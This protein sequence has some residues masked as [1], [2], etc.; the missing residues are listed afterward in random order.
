MVSAQLNLKV[1]TGTVFPNLPMEQSP[2]ETARLP[3][4]NALLEKKEDQ[5]SELSL[6]SLENL[7]ETLAAAAREL[8]EISGSW[9]P[10]ELYTADPESVSAAKEQFLQSYDQGVSSIPQFSYSVAEALDTDSSRHRLHDLLGRVKEERYSRDDRLGRLGR[11]LLIAKIKDD[12]A[13]CDLTQGI[14]DKNEKQIKAALARKYQG[15]DP[16]L[17]AVAHVRY[18][19]LT[20]PEEEASER[21]ALFSPQEQAF[22]HGL[23]LDAGQIK[24]AFEWGLEK[25]GILRTGEEGEGFRVIVDERATAIDVRDKSS[26]GPVVIIP[27][28]RVVDGERILGLLNHEIGSHARQSMNGAKLFKI[29]G[30]SLKIDDETLYEGLAMR[31][32]NAFATAY[33]GKK[34]SYAAPFYTL[35]IEKAE[36]GGTFPDVFQTVLDAKL[37]VALKI[38]PANPLPEDS[39]PAIRKSAKNQAWGITYRVMR[40]HVDMAN[41]EQFAMTKDLAYL[42]GSLLDRQLV[43]EGWGHLNEAAVVAGGGGLRALAEFSLDP[44]DLPIPRADLAKDYFESVLKPRMIMGSLEGMEGGS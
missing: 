2:S 13:T 4:I 38:D 24:D 22:L 25:M 28:T 42:R 36:A 29:G 10:V 41:P 33:F 35:A 39:D 27:A 11:V 15:T 43:A 18:A 12:L 17:I 16:E 1:Y 6:S 21:H 23:Q 5:P 3:E 20:Q 30:G 9:N 19:E 14:Q 8:A 34:E 37:H 40:G 26:Q 44:T 7:P 31:E 32:E